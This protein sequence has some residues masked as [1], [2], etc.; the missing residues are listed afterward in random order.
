MLRLGVGEVAF[1][2]VIAVQILFRSLRVLG[3]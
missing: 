2:R 1:Y 3:M